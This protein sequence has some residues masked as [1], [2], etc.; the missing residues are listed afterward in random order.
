MNKLASFLTFCA[1]LFTTYIQAQDSFSSK[2]ADA[3]LSMEDK[4]YE[5]AL[6]IWKELLQTDP[7]NGNL[8]Y[9]VGLCHFYLPNQ[10]NLSFPYF[11]KA[12]INYT[13]TYDIFSP[14]EKRAPVEVLYYLAETNIL[15]NKIDD[16]VVYFEEFMKAVPKKHILY[17]EAEL[18]IEKCATAREMIANPVNIKVESLGDK[19]N[20]KYHEHSPVLSLDETV[21]YF[22]SRRLRTDSSNFNNVDETT[23]K[24]YEDIYVSYKDENGV[25]QDPGLLPF[26]RRDGH[27]ASVGLNGDGTTLYIYRD[28][29]N[30]SLYESKLVE[31]A[32]TIPTFMKSNINTKYFESHL[33]VSNDNT[34][35]YFASD[36]KGGYGGL[37][38]YVCKRLPN[39]EWS[40]AQNLGP[41]IN[42]KYDDN[43]PYIHPDNKTLYFTSRGHKNMGGYD[44]F[45]AEWQEDGSWTAPKNMGYPIN[46]TGDEL[47]FYTSPDGKRAYYSSAKEGGFGEGDIYVMSMV[48]AEETGLTLVKGKIVI[49]EGMEFPKNLRVVMTDNETGNFV[50]ESRPTKR[51]GSYVFIIPP[52]KNYK[53]T[54]ELDGVEF[55]SESTFVPFGSE[56]KEIQKEI[57]LD[58][59]KIGTDNANKLIVKNVLQDKSPKWQL[60]YK[61][62]KER[63]S[64]GQKAVYMANDGKVLYE[65]PIS[66]EGYFKYYALNENE[67]YY[68]KINNL[69]DYK[70]CEEGEIVL[71]GKDKDSQLLLPDNNCVFTKYSA[72]TAQVISYDKSFFIPKGLKAKYIDAQ[73]NVI[74]VYDVDQKGHFNYYELPNFR[75]YIVVLENASGVKCEDALIVISGNDKQRHYL[76]SSANDCTFKVLDESKF[77]YVGSEIISDATKALY[78]NEEGT[79]M[80]EESITSNTFKYHLLPIDKP[81]RIKFV[82]NDQTL[83]KGGEIHYIRKDGSGYKLKSEEDCIYKIYD[84][85]MPDK[86]KAMFASE[87]LPKKAESVAKVDDKPKTADEKILQKHEESV[88][89]TSRG[90]NELMYKTNFEYN[91][92]KINISDAKFKKFVNDGYALYKKLGTL[93][94]AVESGASKVPTK[95]FKNNE[96]LARLRAYQARDLIIAEL[97]KK[98]VD[99]NKINVRDITYLE[100]GPEYN[101]DAQKISLYKPFQYVKLWVTN[102]NK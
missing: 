36:R 55:Y 25:W 41:V 9:K 63:I 16:A 96:E 61:N 3:N 58:P 81:Y 44:I 23:G 69:Q 60:R 48:D 14:Q 66:E 28:E 10:R 11:E 22:T 67:A 29:V 42:T 40:L 37:D 65:E 30:G 83:C 15:N 51:N 97:V 54:Y 85:L 64:P 35:L 73:N 102:I 84:I 24:Y 87:M 77:A 2:F 43:A 68:F 100:Q 101:Q 92:N 99:K 26:S 70:L 1:V 90:P 32:W 94:I 76:S 45:H 27:D 20:S 34:R 50:A 72:G 75:S 74:A 59:V 93:D 95:T 12:A 8:N 46:T 79:I 6:P 13:K 86:N 78:L 88:V 17:G 39:G 31:D 33:S 49:P 7:E 56:Y 47:S 82:E 4:N 5:Q 89:Q 71:I 91:K 18:G 57:S 53:L 80:F 21:I 98:G 52:G 38:I 62:S 19:I